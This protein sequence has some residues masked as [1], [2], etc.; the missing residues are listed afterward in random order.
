M[1]CSPAHH[2][3]GAPV[4]NHPLKLA[5]Q[6]RNGGAI[7]GGRVEIGLRARSCPWIA[8]LAFRWTRGAPAWMKG[9]ERSDFCS[10]R[11]GVAEGPFPQLQ[12]RLAAAPDAEAA[13]AAGSLLCRRGNRS[14]T[15]A[16]SGTSHGH[17]A[18]RSP[19]GNLIR[20]TGR[21]GKRRDIQARQGDAGVPHVLRAHPRAGRGR[22]A[23]APAQAI[24]GRSWTLPP[25]GCRYSS[26]LSEPSEDD[27]V[28]SRRGSSRRSTR[29]LPGSAMPDE[30][31]VPP[32]RIRTRG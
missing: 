32:P 8:R 24:S 5:G 15:P 22:R 27:R 1:T 26:L 7:S 9:S 14:R 21:P 18:R 17:S 16:R 11:R 4:F 23:R 28:H 13:A 29:A 20:S 3:G 2:R 31:S 25:N 19:H 12:G 10:R 30:I 6:I